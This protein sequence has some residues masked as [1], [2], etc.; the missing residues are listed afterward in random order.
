MNSERKK[1]DNEIQNAMH[2]VLCKDHQECEEYGQESN[3]IK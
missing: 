3:K 2:R 1:C